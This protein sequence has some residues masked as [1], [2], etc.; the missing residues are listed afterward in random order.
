MVT[1]A[2]TGF[3]GMVV[4]QVMKPLRKLLSA[5]YLTTPDVT[6]HADLRRLW[7]A[8]MAT[9]VSL[10]VL[11]VMAGGLTVMGYE[12]VQTRYA[13]K[14]IAPR[15]VIGL[16]AAASSLTVMGK[17][18]ALANALS[19]S[20]MGTDLADAGQGLVEKSLPF[21]AFGVKGLAVYLIL[22]AIVAAALM[23]G[24]LMG[25]IVRVAF[26]AILA[27]AAPLALAC[28]AHPVTEAVA[29]LWCRA[30][31]A[32]LTIQIAQSLTFIV[33]L[34]LF[35]APGST[36]LG[37]P[38]PNQLGTTLAGIALFWVLFKIPGWCM[39]FIFRSTVL[40]TPHSPAPL[41]M[42][43]NTAML[44]L[45]RRTSLPAPARR[46]PRSPGPGGTPPGNGSGGT[47]PGPTGG[48][49]PRPTPAPGGP[50]N[51]PGPRPTPPPGPVPAPGNA[52][53]GPTPGTPPGP[54]GGGNTTVSTAGTSSPNVPPPVN[55]TGRWAPTGSTFP[56][57]RP[58]PSPSNL[59]PG[60]PGR[61]RPG[62]LVQGPGALS[63]PPASS[64]TAWPPPPPTAGRGGPATGTTR[65]SPPSPSSRSAPP[66]TTPVVSGPAPRA[67][68]QPK[69]AAPA[70]KTPLGASAPVRRPHA[71]PTAVRPARSL[72]L[73][74]PLEPPRS[75][76]RTE[77]P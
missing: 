74:L 62:A 55:V 22:L 24:V 40:T 42:A 34:K 64:R 8:S 16:I 4:D 53:G 36:L 49:G 61:T 44:M 29:R 32:C 19:A 30:L 47:P 54:P 75:H 39:R 60:G 14:Q 56:A 65:S 46:Q 73:Q 69:R 57:R 72:R 70:R 59:S 28:H 10:Y 58:G 48:P 7:K 11:F 2:V 67:A 33:A 6:E 63:T 41:R 43:R 27:V 9:A 50:T 17:A 68:R 18:I 71:P 5:T 31:G 21:M 76:R 20:I 1:D 66:R 51:S 15:L 12:T 37:L 23:L 3:L 52:G 13:L 38:K 25:Y 26:M 45:L 77:G 35:F